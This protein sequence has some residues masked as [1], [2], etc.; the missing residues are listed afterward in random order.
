MKTCMF[1]RVH[2][3][4][5]SDVSCGL[6]VCSV[7]DHSHRRYSAAGGVHGHACTC[8]CMNIIELLHVDLS[9]HMEPLIAWL[10]LAL[11]HSFHR[12][13]G[14]LHAL[15]SLW[16]VQIKQHN[17]FVVALLHGYRCPTAPPPPSY[18]HLLYAGD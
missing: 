3:M 1:I 14:S 4:A 10:A 6:L 13:P 11:V 15:G 5:G 8:R 18:V 9:M 16:L 7:T 17:L 12:D 2:V